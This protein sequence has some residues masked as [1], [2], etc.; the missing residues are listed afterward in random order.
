MA[1]RRVNADQKLNEK[2]PHAPAD[3]PSDIR[4]A[5]ESYVSHFLH[6]L[7][8][9]HSFVSQSQRNLD[10]LMRLSDHLIHLNV[11]CLILSLGSY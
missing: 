8:H 11:F 4:P 2:D 3:G 10:A 5:V 9:H 7:H 1:T 6:S